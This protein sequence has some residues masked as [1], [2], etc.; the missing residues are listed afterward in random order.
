MGYYVRI[1][2]SVT[3]H[4]KFRGFRTGRGAG[5]DTLGAKLG[6]QLVGLAHEPLFQVLLDVH[7]AYNSLDRGRCMEILQGCGMVHNM[8][9]LISQH[10]DNQSFFPK[11]VRFLGMSFSTGRWVMQGDPATPMIFKIVVD[12]VVRA[13]LEVVC[14]PQ[15]A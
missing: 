13:F 10:W 2:Q 9:R 7:K 15:E 4:Y 8:A 6:Q 14:V 3:L 11:L 5:I 12:A 1:K